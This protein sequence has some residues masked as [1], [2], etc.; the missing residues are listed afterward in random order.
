MYAMRLR[1]PG[2]SDTN[3][4]TELINSLPKLN[5]K[6]D[7][8]PISFDCG[9]GK[10]SVLNMMEK[11]GFVSKTIATSVGARHPFI[12]QDDV[13]KHFKQY[14]SIGKNKKEKEYVQKNI[15]EKQRIILPWTFGS[16][17]YYGSESRIA[18][19]IIC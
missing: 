13:D 18:K 2:E 19:K 16:E 12:L 7:N 3:N 4:L 17:E 11:K 1:L 14:K 9:Y 8:V 6:E 5:K 10:M 15:H